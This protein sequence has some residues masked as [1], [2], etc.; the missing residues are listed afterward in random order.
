MNA[1]TPDDKENVGVTK[2]QLDE[3][4]DKPVEEVVA[5]FAAK[6]SLA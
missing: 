6:S 4:F 3:L 2:G 1:D 5:A